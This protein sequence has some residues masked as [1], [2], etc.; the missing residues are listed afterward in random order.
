MRVNKQIRARQV[1]LISENG[2]QIGIV[3]LEQAFEKAREAGLDLVEVAADGN[4]PVCR[5][6][7]YG[8]LKYDQKK[9]EQES[10]KKQ[11]VIRVKE[12][13][14]R[15]RI[16]DNDFET[17]IRNAKKF[18]TE[19]YKVKITLMFRGREM[20]RQDLGQDLLTRIEAT[21]DGIAEVEKRGEM[22]GRRLSVIMTPR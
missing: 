14:F 16:S 10:R 13:R 17:K 20:V 19:G 3:D 5:L 12:V 2:T 11:H 18:L 1:R 4:P 15:P 21:L 8:K 6:M 7:D 9:K 22:E